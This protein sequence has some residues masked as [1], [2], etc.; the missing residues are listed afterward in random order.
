MLLELDGRG[1]RYGQM[2]RA[3]LKAIG[4][5]T[6]S[7]GARVPS[8]RRLARDL[9]CARN[10]VILAYEEHLPSHCFRL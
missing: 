1:P 7:P 2:T 8:T 4:D 3:L 6:L 10:I 9:G 5:G